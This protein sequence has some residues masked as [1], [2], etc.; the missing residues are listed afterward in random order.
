MTDYNSDVKAIL[1]RILKSYGVSSRPEL[2]ELLKI[3]LPTIQNWVARQSLPGD[4]IVQCALDT[5]VSLRWLVNGELANVSSD[6]VRHPSL[7]GKKLHDTM[8]ANG[9]RAVLDRIMHAY[10][11]TMQKQLG[12]LLHIP[13]ATMSA[14]VRRDYFPGDVVITCA[15]DTGVSLS[16]LATGH[17]D[18]ALPT[19]DLADQLIPSIPARKLSGGTL[20]NQADVSFNLSLFGL[21]LTNPL[22]I[23]RGSMSWIV[24]GDAQTIGNGDWL[25]DIDGN[26]DIYTVSRLPGNRIKVTNNSS[27]FECSESDVTPIGFV[28]LAISKYL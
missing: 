6:G 22:Y 15:L 3:P 25:L 14:W 23:Q 4:Y 8:L 12:D 11:F 17:E 16:W 13:S 24:E 28:M 10:G 9:G 5:G 1:D 20:E 19:R 2:A 7:K 18:E 21:D 26:K 27:S